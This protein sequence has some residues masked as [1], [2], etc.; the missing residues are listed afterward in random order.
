MRIHSLPGAAQVI[1]DVEGKPGAAAKL[2]ARSGVTLCTTVNPIEV[3]RAVDRA[4]RSGIRLGDE[5]QAWLRVNPAS[6]QS[7]RSKP[8][9]RDWNGG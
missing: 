8:K 9:V 1:S 2:H 7:S 6:N 5:L 4:D 3:D